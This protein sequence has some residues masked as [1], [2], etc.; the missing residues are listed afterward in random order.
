MKKIILLMLLL[1][2]SITLIACQDITSTTNTTTTQTTTSEAPTTVLTTKPWVY[3]TEN[4]ELSYSERVALYNNIY[5]I[6]LFVTADVSTSIGINFELP[7]DEKGFVEY[8]PVGASEIITEEATHKATVVGKRTVHHYE[9]VLTDLTP[10]TVYEYR[11]RNE[12]GD[13]VSEVYQFKTKQVNPDSFSFLFIAD[14]QENS[15]LGYMAYSHAILNV[16]DEVDQKPDFMMFAGDIVNDADVRSEWNNFFTYSSPFIYTTP[17]IATTGNHDIAGISGNRMTNIEF[18]GYFNLPN[19]GPVYSPFDEIEND[20]RPANFDD[21][22]TY[23]FNYDNTHFVAINTESLC[24]GTTACSQFD[25]TNV[26]LLKAWLNQDLSSHTMKWTIVIMH[27]GAYSLS[28]NTFKVRE[29]LVPIFEANDVDLVISG[30]DHQYSRSVYYNQKL[31]NFNRS[32][33]YTSGTLSLISS[34]DTDYH[35][36]D[37]SSSI[38]VTYLVGNTAGTKYY[39][40]EKNS[41]ISTHY[42]FTDSHPVVPYIKITDSSIEVISYGLSKSSE[43]QIE[44]DSVYILESFTISK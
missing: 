24:D 17:I 15:V 33:I 27:R 44:V 32:D 18:D 5:N 22:K 20:V 7:K 28:Y 13:S 41:G 8:K 14:P 21:G 36:N 31:L 11:V 16:M 10:D 12:I 3:Q 38:G 1:M 25:T 37:Y 35:F 23:S 34:L 26:E 29:E 43:L 4:T 19:N 30:H 39:G 6:G 9:L 2:T 40:G 42:S